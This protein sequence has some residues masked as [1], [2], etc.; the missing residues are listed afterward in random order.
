MRNIGTMERKERNV[1]GAFGNIHQRRC[2]QP[3]VPEY[4]EDCL[5]LHDIEGVTYEGKPLNYD[6]LLDTALEQAF[7]GM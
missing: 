4:F 1:Q 3:E 6:I 5:D 7:E 2:E